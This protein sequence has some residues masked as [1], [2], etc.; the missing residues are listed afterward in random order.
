MGHHRRMGIYVGFQSPSILKYLEPLTGD[1]FM[2]LFADCIFNEDHFSVLGEDNKFITHG[3][4]INWD[5]KCILSSDPRIK[6]TEL[7]VQKII[8]LHQIVSNLPDAFTDYKGV[9]KSLNLAVNTSCRVEIPIKPTSPPKGG[10]VVSKKMLPTSI[11]R[12]R[13]KYLPQKK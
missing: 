11:R 10:G 3:W 9:T 13:G 12:L 4:D 5:D 8:E 6:E 7:Q 2:T 1:L